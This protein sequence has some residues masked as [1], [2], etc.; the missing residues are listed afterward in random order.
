[1][2]FDG[3]NFRKT[4]KVVPLPKKYWLGDTKN[5]VVF[6]TICPPETVG[7]IKTDYATCMGLK[8]VY[9]LPIECKGHSLTNKM[10]GSKY[11]YLLI[12]DVTYTSLIKDNP[13]DF[14]KNIGKKCSKISG[15][16]FLSK[17]KINTIKGV[18]EHQELGVP[19]YI[20]EED[21]SY[22][23]CKRCKIEES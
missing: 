9:A 7:A 14:E 19:A 12:N 4:S 15:K 16:P 5:H 2:V 18:I 23:E 11:Y 1:M 8:R 21:R 17:S 10:R 6:G 22:V 3:R 13:E 20:F